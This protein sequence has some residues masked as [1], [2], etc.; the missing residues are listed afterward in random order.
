MPRQKRHD[1]INSFHLAAIERQ[2]SLLKICLTDA[3]RS[4]S[5][6]EAHYDAISSLWDQLRIALNLL[7]DR[8]ADY[9]Q[10]H[11]APM[12]GSA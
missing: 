3:Q 9:R 1:K 11:Q 10:P 8:P 2:V 5:P 6:F 12:S 7:N 4:L